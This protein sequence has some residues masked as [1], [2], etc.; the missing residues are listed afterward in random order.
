M[1]KRLLSFATGLRR[2]LVLNV[3]AQW[4][5]MLANVAAVFSL[6]WVLAR[7]Q[8]ATGG[9]GASGSVG[10][11]ELLVVAGVF[12]V[13]LVVRFACGFVAARASHR[14]CCGVKAKMR[15]AVYGKLLELGPSYT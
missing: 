12:V 8:G 2:W 9:T 4:F 15:D 3:A 13:A 5:A 6:G 11:R 10:A 7:L 1:D 14:V